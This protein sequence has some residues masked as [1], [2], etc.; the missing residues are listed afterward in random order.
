MGIIGAKRNDSLV[1][2][3]APDV[4]FKVS[5]FLKSYSEIAA[6]AAISE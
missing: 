5:S 4:N 6:A 3:G 1:V 2:G